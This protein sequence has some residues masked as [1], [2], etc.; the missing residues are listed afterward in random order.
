MHPKLR[1]MFAGAPA[2]VEVFLQYSVVRAKTEVIAS[3]LLL[4]SSLSTMRRELAR[5]R[6]LLIT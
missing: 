6:D 5:I 1:G 4:K 2:L 3:K